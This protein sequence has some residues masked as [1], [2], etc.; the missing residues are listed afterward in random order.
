MQLMPKQLIGN[1]GGAYLK[2]SK[3]VLFHPQPCEAL[4]SLTKVMSSGFVSFFLLFFRYY[5]Y[6]FTHFQ[7]GC[8]H[9]TSIPN[10]SACDIKVLI[11]LYT[12]EKRAYL[13]FIP[14][15]QTAFVDRLRKVIQQQKS[16]QMMRQTQGGAGPSLNPQ[17]SWKR[18]I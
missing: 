7:A 4:E 15:D 8:V 1:I 17:V 3:S 18:I 5:F 2:N 16:T 9:F 10:P 11:L 14:N 12:N 13:G 6:L